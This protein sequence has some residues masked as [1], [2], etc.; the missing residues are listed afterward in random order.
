MRFI[1]AFLFMLVSTAMLAQPNEAKLFSAK[2]ILT[3]IEGTTTSI[4]FVKNVLFPYAKTHVFDYLIAHEH[5]E[6]V[7]SIISEIRQMIQSPEA[8][9]STIASTLLT[10]ME[11]DK[12]FTPLKTLQGL[13]WEDGYH[14]G[15]FHGHI[16]EDVYPQLQKWNDQGIALYI[17]SS[18]SVFAQKLLFGYTKFGDLTHLFSGYFDTRIGIKKESAA[19]AAIAKEIGCEPE[20]ILFL[21]DSI[22]ELDAAQSIGMQTVMLCRDEDTFD[23]PSL[24]PS[25]SSF[26]SILMMKPCG[27]INK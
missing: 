3:D 15:E 9:L 12:K 5:D 16:Y 25:V 6:A 19:Y 24:H 26:D 14:R 10:W 23:H 11:Q 17:Y 8:D 1:F 27:M 4:T 2:A 13:I 22:V 7:S 21:S 18:G 20:E